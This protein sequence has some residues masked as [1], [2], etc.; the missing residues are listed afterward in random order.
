MK[1]NEN[2]T[3]EE[4]SLLGARLIERVTRTRN[5][6]DDTI[7]TYNLYQLKVRTS[8]F[9]N[10]NYIIVDK[11]TGK[12]AIIDPAWEKE[13]ILSLF[14]EISAKPD[15][16][17]LTHSHHDHINQ[18]D[19]LV[20]QFGSR[21]Y[22]S[23][24]EIDFYHFNCKNLHPTQDGESIS[25]G[26]TPITCLLTPGHTAGGTCYLIPGSLFTGDTIFIEGCGMCSTPG[27]SPDQLFESIQRLKQTI[28]P[29]V[30]IYPGHSFGKTP[31]ETMDSLFEENIY[32]QIESKEHFIQFRMRENQISLFDFK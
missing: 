24:K 20:E 30:R 27:G 2:R 18:V 13:R 4:R 22:M 7:S 17:L 14:R 1:N 8:A 5:D 15:V 9:I 6:E 32:F 16:I 29:H 11:A 19:Q 21:V 31:G 26:Q 10:F 25:L 28:G 3:E 12:A 23:A